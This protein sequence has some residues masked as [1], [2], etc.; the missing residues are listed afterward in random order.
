MSTS[1]CFSVAKPHKTLAPDPLFVCAVNILQEIHN[2]EQD[3]LIKKSG[4]LKVLN[5]LLAKPKLDKPVAL[6]FSSVDQSK[7]MMQTVVG[8]WF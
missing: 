8:K 6:A 1:E 3:W 2:Y 5:K 4:N 7:S